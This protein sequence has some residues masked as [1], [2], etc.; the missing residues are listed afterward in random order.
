MDRE[1]SRLK[2][3]LTATQNIN[4]NEKKIN[5]KKNKRDPYLEALLQLCA[6]SGTQVYLKYPTWKIFSAAAMWQK[7]A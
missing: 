2:K 6:S 5:A 7:V 3:M 4:T 1:T